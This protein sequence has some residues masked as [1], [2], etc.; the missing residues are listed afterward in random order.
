MGEGELCGWEGVYEN[1]F[2]N[3]IFF[4]VVREIGIFLCECLINVLLEV[5]LFFL[6][7]WVVIVFKSF[8][9]S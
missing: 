5:Y 2:F 8:V 6:I 9:D 4:V 7:W 1:I 3:Y